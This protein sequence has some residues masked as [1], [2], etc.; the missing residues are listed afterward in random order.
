MEILRLSLGFSRLKLKNRQLLSGG[1]SGNFQ[2]LPGL[3]CYFLSLDHRHSILYL[4]NNKI[5]FSLFT[6][7]CDSQGRVSA[8]KNPCLDGVHVD[9]LPFSKCSMWIPSIQSLLSSEEMQVPELASVPFCWVALSV[10]V[11]CWS[12]SRA[13]TSWIQSICRWALARVQANF[14]S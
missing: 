11:P 7:P 2:H 4:Y 8:S 10:T 1:S 5:T 12:L 3:V 13:S 14:T 6:A 9:T